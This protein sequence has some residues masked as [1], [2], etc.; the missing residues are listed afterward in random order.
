[1]TS[2][3]KIKELEAQLG[4]ANH[5]LNNLKDRDEYS[6]VTIDNDQLIITELLDQIK[7]RR[8]LARA[9][10]TILKLSTQ[11]LGQP[12]MESFYIPTEAFTL[13]DTY[14]RIIEE[15]SAPSSKS[16]PSKSKKDIK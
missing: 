15:L 10:M 13:I 12:T 11:R 2:A 9:I 4:L 14:L 5:E 6:R 8:D 1:M 16:T 7:L 3:E